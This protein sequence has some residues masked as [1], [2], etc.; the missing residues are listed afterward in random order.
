MN[1]ADATATPMF[2]VFTDTP[3]TALYLHEE[4]RIPLDEMNPPMTALTGQDLYFARES[5]RLASLGIDAGE[6]DLMNRIIWRSFRNDAPYPEH[7]AGH[8]DDD[9]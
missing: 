8:D 7:L 1:M 9:D 2:D 4:N 6:D 3:D 5:S